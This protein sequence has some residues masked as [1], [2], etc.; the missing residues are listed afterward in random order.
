[1]FMQR[2]GPR[3]DIIDFRIGRNGWGH[4][5]HAS[6]FREERPRVTGYLWWRRSYPR[7]SVMVHTQD[8]RVGDTII[9]TAPDRTDRWATI[10]EI[11]PCHDPRDMFT[12]VLED[13]RRTESKD[14][15]NDPQ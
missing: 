12:L 15:S 7:F 10:A 5:I 1:M 11:K 14:G 2:L 8:P 9:Y 13:V 3:S 4:S 6:T